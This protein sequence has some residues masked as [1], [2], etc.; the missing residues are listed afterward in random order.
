M[1]EEE[2]KPG[3]AD[4]R[5]KKLYMR[6]AKGAAGRS[7]YKSK[8]QGLEND[9]FDVGAS[10]N[11]AKFSKSL[12]NIK[13]YIQ[14]TYK[15][16]DNMVKTIQKMKWVIL[17]YPEKPKKTDAACCNAIGDPDPDMFEMDIFAWKEDYKSMISRM[18]KY[19]GN[20]SSVWALIYDQCL[21]ELK[22]KLK[23]TQG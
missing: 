15:D 11:P 10:S 17:K 4:N 3:G 14:K 5:K 23:G 8:V 18:E 16:Q 9:T 7:T 1:A 13:N 21:A 6:F 22:N 19:K 20:K 12:K 2:K